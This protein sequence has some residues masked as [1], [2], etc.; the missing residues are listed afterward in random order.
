VNRWLIAGAGGM[1]G[2]D[3]LARL[4]CDGAPVT[5]LA[6]RDLDVTDTAAVR[7]AFRRSRPDVVV[8]CAAWTA[9]DAAEAHESEALA[10]NGH[11]AA[12]LAAAC[13][14]GGARLVQVSTD[15]VFDGTARRPYAEDAVPAPRTA[16][17]RTKLAGEQAVLRQLGEASYVVRT[18]WLYGA[19]GPNFVRTM[20]DLLRQRPGVDV[21]D[22]QRGQPTWTGDVAVAIHAL[23]TADAPAGVYHATSSGET[24]WFGLAQEVFRL[25]QSAQ[26]ADPQDLQN[27]QKAD[28]E[29]TV[30][31]PRPISTAEYPLPA[32][33]PAYSVLGH[34][35]WAAAGIAPIGDWRDALHRAFPAMLAA[36]PR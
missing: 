24:T 32:P 20:I 1:L 19:H 18:A 14:A 31:S 17:G 34:A 22:D 21:V 5:A 8:N 26:A 36:G 13:F 7:D 27:P 29:R 6:R 23:V 16:Y 4:R 15:Y 33:R 28:V 35:A 9:V 10:V 30:I 12:N 2:R 11:G 3:L 25:Y